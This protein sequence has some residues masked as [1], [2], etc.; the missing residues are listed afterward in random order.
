MSHPS[1]SEKK[2]IIQLFNDSVRGKRPD[3]RNFNSN[4]DGNEGHWLE[5]Q[6]GIA[7]NCSNSPDF[8]W[9]EMKNH[10]ASKTSFGDWSAS[11]YIFK[12]KNHSISRQRFMEIFGQYNFLKKRYSWSGTPI[13]KIGEFN[14]FGQI[15]LVNN[16]GDINIFYS[17]THDKRT[18]KASIVPESFQQGQILIVQW[19]AAW[20]GKKVENKFNKAGWF[21]CKQNAAGVYSEIVFGGPLNYPSFLQGVKKGVIFFDSGMYQGNPRNYSQWRA[22]NRLWD[23]LITEKY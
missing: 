18:E 20:M 3:V 1:E 9:F 11:Y 19:N 10:T 16:N 7:H 5:K 14:Q 6:M 17:Y 15:L 4:H 8:M 2:L 21:K 12:D 13:P 22:D 23:S